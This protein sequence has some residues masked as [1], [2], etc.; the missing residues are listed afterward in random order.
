M[1]F[2]NDDEYGFPAK[3]YGWGWG[4]PVAWQ[5]WLVIALYALL[6][7]VGAESKRVS[8]CAGAC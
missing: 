8:V 7:I 1:V 2:E 6:A 4:L 5:G 3:R